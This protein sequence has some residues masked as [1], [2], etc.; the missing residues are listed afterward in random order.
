MRISLNWLQ[1]YISVQSDPTELANQLTL[2]GLEVEEIIETGDRFTHVVIG[3][4]LQKEK[5]PNAD[6]LS[7]CQ[8][9]TGKET[10]QIV[11]GAPNVEKGQIVPVAIVGAE[12]PGGFSIK[13]VKLRG[14]DSCGMICSSRE[15]GIDSHHE[16]ILVLDENAGSPGDPYTSGKLSD[17]ILN[18]NVTPNRPD[19]LSHIG[20]AREVSVIEKTSVRI[21]DISIPKSDRPASD[22]I[23]IE[24]KDPVGC[25]RYVTRVIENVR[26]GPSPEW[27]KTALESVGVRSINNVV[28][29]TNFVLMETGHPLHAFDYQTIAKQRIIVRKAHKNETFITLDDMKRSLTEEDLL[30]CD[31]E[32]PVALAGIMGG[33][34][35]EVTDATQTILLE[36]AYFDPMTIRRTA[37]RLGMSTEAS[38]R[39]ERGADPENTL[40]AIDRAAQ[41]ICELASGTVLDG[42]V[43]AYPHQ[44]ENQ[45]IECRISRIAHV[46][47]IEIERD[48]IISILNGL[49]LQV[50]GQDP[51]LVTVPT[52]RPDLTREI[53]L[54]EEIVRH[55]GYDKIPANMHS[56][57][58]LTAETNASYDFNEL[59][60]DILIGLGFMDTINNSL[61][62]KMFVEFDAVR[63]T[64]VCI[65]NPLSPETAFY[66]NH[67]YPNLLQDIVWNRNRGHHNLRLFE[68]ARIG[69]YAADNV[70]VEEVRLAG[71]LTGQKNQSFWGSANEPLSFYQIKGFVAALM[72]KL[73]IRYSIKPCD[74]PMY[75]SE[76]AVQMMIGPKVAGVF[77]QISPNMQRAFD[78]DIPVYG[79]DFSMETL[80][81]NYQKIIQFKP[82]SRFPAVKRDLALVVNQ[83]TK[84]GDLLQAI[85]SETGE[86][87]RSV[88]LFDLYQGE[89]LPKDKISLAFSLTFNSDE[90][91]LTDKDVEPVIGRLLTKLDREFSAKLRT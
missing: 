76:R 52:F 36:A 8:V 3:K 78:L 48:Q 42:R 37:R 30:I 86:Y 13:P 25:P 15:L 50:Q 34:N 84:A 80:F 53:D 29:V 20:I 23:S 55:Y 18:I 32:R 64:P 60:R 63:K 5:H 7:I 46:L 74:D 19:C 41:L 66:R 45:V 62:P 70:K 2:A 65:E 56:L 43:D 61:V 17:T 4:V 47:G 40:F 71:M 9:D 89:S 10:L 6:K 26:I 31:G 21:P 85:E 77:G 83:T 1:K 58:S 59:C 87:F 57:L 44:I 28:D 67:L 54:I 22:A 91:T 72:K 33:L 49:G 90:R 73:N 39:F 79:F 69:Y 51:L 68:I 82:F 38:Q 88:E 81:E 27:L 12:L 16:G 11:C 75:L 24:I 35:S 14:V